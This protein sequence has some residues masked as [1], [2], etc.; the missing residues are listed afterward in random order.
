MT[1][2]GY[3]HSTAAKQHI[4]LYNFHKFSFVTKTQPNCALFG[5][6]G[7]LFVCYGG[8]FKEANRNKEIYTNIPRVNSILVFPLILRAAAQLVQDPHKCRIWML[9]SLIREH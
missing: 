3:V 4:A 7:I 6:T 1:L 5:T 8:H 2:G 9:P